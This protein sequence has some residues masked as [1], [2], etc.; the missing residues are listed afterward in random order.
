[1]CLVSIII[2]CYNEQTTIHWL[3]DAIY[4]QTFPIEQIEVIISDGLSTDLTR[5]EIEKFQLQH[6][7][8]QILMVDNHKRIIPAALNRALS[9]A[10]GKYI[11]RLDAHSIPASDYIERC[12]SGLKADKGD[13]VG[14][15]WEIKP[16]NESWVARSIAAAAAHP[17]GVGD[18]H[19]RTH[20]QRQ[21]N[22]ITG[23]LVDT[24]P[25]GAF[26]RDI[27]NKIGGFDENLL[28]NEDYEFNARLRKIGGRIWFDPDIRSTYFARPNLYSLARQYWR[29]G[30]W[31]WRMI[32]RY[33]STVKLRQALP[34]LF[35]FSLILLILLAPFSVF[36]SYMLS[37][38]LL[39]YLFILL[40][41]VFP[42]VLNRKD[43]FLWLGM[44]VAIATMHISWGTGLLWSMFSSIIGLNK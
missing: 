25:F 35:S 8:L 15:V 38:E 12:I 34:P 32:R 17:L 27:F 21:T 4:H 44:P 13:N 22:P 40:M 2:P 33:P 39:L 14:G 41:G 10:K 7:D 6:K 5:E 20:K 37:L 30:Y 28:S 3:L 16:G 11:V 43:F 23:G 18:A 9:V 1:M 24:V 19:Y 36:F 31:K 29:Y 26:K 42:T